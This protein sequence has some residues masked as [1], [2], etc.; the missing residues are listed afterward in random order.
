MKVNLRMIS[1][2]VENFEDPEIQDLLEAIRAELKSDARKTSN[3]EA[4]VFLIDLADK[5]MNEGIWG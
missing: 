1:D 3:K 4:R 5:V 2:V